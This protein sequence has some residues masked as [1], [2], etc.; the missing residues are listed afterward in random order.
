MKYAIV[1]CRDLKYEVIY[2]NF[3]MRTRSKYMELC[4][5]MHADKN[6]DILGAFYGVTSE[7]LENI[8]YKRIESH[9]MDLVRLGFMPTNLPRGFMDRNYKVLLDEGAITLGMIYRKRIT[10]EWR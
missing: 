2:R 9:A 10:G 3:K 6:F 7:D 1:I 8:I 4:D 5:Q